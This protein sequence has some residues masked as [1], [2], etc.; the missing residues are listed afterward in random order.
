MKHICKKAALILAVFTAAGA[1]FAATAGPATGSA[2]AVIIAPMT[3]TH[4]TNASLNF[5]RIVNT[6]A[7]TVTV[8]AKDGTSTSTGVTYQEGPT[9]ADQFTVTGQNGVSFTVNLP[10]SITVTDGAG[11]NMTVGS[12]T[13]FCGTGASSACTASTTGT[14]VGVGG[15]LTVSAGQAAGTYT[16]TYSVTITY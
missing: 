15:T 9:A 3:L 5:G 12:L 10:A 4:V 13:S 14:Q 7:G 8:A 16:G 1:L 6:A 2:K 11:N